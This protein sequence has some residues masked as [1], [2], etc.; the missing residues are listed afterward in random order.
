[1]SS[2]EL[3]ESLLHLFSTF[4]SSQWTLKRFPYKFLDSFEKARSAQNP[5]TSRIFLDAGFQAWVAYFIV[6]PGS[7]NANGQSA[8]RQLFASLDSV[9]AEDRADLA[10]RVNA[11]PPHPTVATHIESMQQ[12]TQ[13]LVDGPVSSKRRREY[14]VRWHYYV[15]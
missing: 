1:M 13:Q 7:A 15:C 12:Q 6:K 4:L 14:L 11:V 10:K 2:S 3:I 8:R 5:N 9:S